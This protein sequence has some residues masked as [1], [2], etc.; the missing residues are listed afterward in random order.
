[1][2]VNGAERAYRNPSCED[3]GTHSTAEKH[4][5]AKLAPAHK[6]PFQDH[7]VDRA[8]PER[9]RCEVSRH[10]VLTTRQ[11]SQSLVYESSGRRWTFS[12]RPILAM[13]ELAELATQRARWLMV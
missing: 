7:R 13:A 12:V 4:K 10:L 11:N 3:R 5:R 6:V 8:R 1:M 9:L 2:P